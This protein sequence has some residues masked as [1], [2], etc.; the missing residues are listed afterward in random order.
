MKQR[1]NSK[2]RSFFRKAIFVFITVFLSFLLIILF[3]E[4]VLRIAG[5]SPFQVE[6][7]DIRVSGG[8]FFRSDSLLGFNTF[9]GEFDIT[10]P[11]DFKFQITHDSQNRRVTKDLTDTSLWEHS[12]EIGFFGC[13]YT[14]G[15]S[16][17]DSETFAWKLQNIFPGQRLYN[18]GKSGFSTL[19]SLLQLKKLAASNRLPGFVIL[20]YASFHDERNTSSLNWRKNLVQ[21]N[22]LGSLN[23]PIATINNDTLQIT[24]PVLNF[25]PFFLSK[26]LALANLL[27]SWFSELNKN[28]KS[29]EIITKKIMLEIDK[30]CRSNASVFAVAGITGDHH[31][32]SMLEFLNDNNISTSDI[33]IDLNIPEYT[34]L[35]FDSHPSDM[36]N[37]KYAEKLSPFIKHILMNNNSPK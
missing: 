5:F 10:L 21:F 31:T 11:Q 37:T 16:L 7:K 8:S 34:N 25:K 4:F 6:T 9:P 15:W 30:V 36:A 29:S 23:H 18:F 17:N 20:I 28:K 32:I 26:Y 12:N 22:R 2:N 33:S 27:E 13:S 35:P 3:L 19:Q 14:H 1:V 24:Y